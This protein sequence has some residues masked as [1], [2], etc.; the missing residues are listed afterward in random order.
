MG[1]LVEPRNA[2]STARR[3]VQSK[4]YNDCRSQ[5]REGVSPEYIKIFFH[6]GYLVFIAK[7]A[8]PRRQ[9]AEIASEVQPEIKEQV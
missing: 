2:G 4:E 6:N 1:N 5:Q 7:K 9:H 8:V 3:L